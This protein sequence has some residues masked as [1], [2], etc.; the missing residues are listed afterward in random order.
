[1]APAVQERRCLRTGGQI[2]YGDVVESAGG[3]LER[4]GLGLQVFT[5]RTVL[6]EQVVWGRYQGTFQKDMLTGQ[7]IQ[8]WYDGSV[9]EGNFLNGC[10]HGHGIFTWPEGSTYDGMWEQ[11]EMTGQ[12]SFFSKFEGKSMSGVFHRNCIR[13]HDGTWVDVLRC[14]EEQRRARLR[15]DP[16]LSL[17]GA[18]GSRPPPPVLRCRPE[19]LIAR[20]ATMLFE[21]PFLVPLVLAAA[22]CPEGPSPA[23]LWCLEAGDHG[24]IPLTSVHLAYAAS[25]KR[26]RRDY[27]ALFR[28][29]I[30]EALLTCRTFCLVFG[31]DP[32]GEDVKNP[33]EAP[34]SWSVS[35]FFDDTSLP[36]DTFDLRHF[37]GFGGQNRFLP[38]DK[39]GWH[40]PIAEPGTPAH[41]P[42]PAALSEPAATPTGETAASPQPTVPPLLAPATLYLLHFALVSL[43]RIA[44]GL[45]D[46]A[47]E[48]TFGFDLEVVSRCSAWVSSLCPPPDGNKA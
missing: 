45:N 44:G 2:Y 29:A 21:P 7:G 10:L 3:C 33:D 6:G 23:P 40:C 5:A 20:A 47:V 48:N 46:D 22:D 25:E 27:A 8:R 43:R 16:P 42:S 37:H 19:E 41:A 39:R 11:G 36:L 18:D 15:I 9:F 30:Q 13:T 14:R 17:L 31:D 24:C 1:M 28:K 26:R 12:G 35:E 38:D 32:G 4:Q 34:N